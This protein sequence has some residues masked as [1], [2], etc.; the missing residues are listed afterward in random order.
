MDLASF[1]PLRDDEARKGL[2]GRIVVAG[3]SLRYTGAP[4]FNA[5]AA[6]RTGADLAVVVAPR[7]AADVVASFAPDLI[8]VPCDAPYP[9]ARL[10]LEET[11]HADVLVLGGGVERTPAA[12]AALREILEGARCPVVTDAEALHA[13]APTAIALPDRSVLTPNAREFE[14]VAGRPWPLRMPEREEAAKALARARGCAV[15]VKGRFDVVSD[16]ARVDV[17]PE[18][19]PYLTK[20]GQGDLLAGAIAAFLAR[21]ANGFEAARAG[22]FVVGRAGAIAAAVLGEATLASDVLARIPAVLPRAPG[23]P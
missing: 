12:H 7:R 6:L 23:T 14:V 17:D 10:V 2:F 19:S 9:E 16:G 4:A 21:G 18:G 5:L 1:Y 8:T 15:V 20:G 22:A 3:G 11:A 13:L